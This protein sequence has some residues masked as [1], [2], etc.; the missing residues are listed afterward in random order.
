MGK[1]VKVVVIGGGIIGLNATEKL[2]SLGHDVTL[3]EKDE[4]A[5]GAS[6]GNAA[7][8]AFPEIMPLASPGIIGQAIKWMLDPL[9]PFA[10]VPQ[11]LPKTLGWLL[12]FLKASS[13][14]QFEKSIKVQGSLMGLA[15][16]SFDVMLKRR[17]LE[18]LVWTQGALHLYQKKSAFNKDLET[19]KL[20]EKKGVPFSIY[21]GEALH[22]FQPGLDRSFIA[23]FYTPTWKTVT[24]PN[25][26]CQTLHKCLTDSGVETIFSGVE[27]IEPNRVYLENGQILKADKIVLAAGPWS[28]KFTAE[29]GDKIPL[30]GERGYNTTLPKTA[31]DGLNR[32]LVFSEHGFIVGPLKDGVRVGGASEIAKLGR[33]ENFKRSR[34]MLTKASR[35]IPN[36][37][38]ENGVEWMGARPSMPDTLPVIGYSTASKDIIYAFGHGHVGLTQS[39]ATAQLVSELVEEITPSIDITALRPDRF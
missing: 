38:T 14:K 8:L 32:T 19:W 27:K 29:L 21:E 35:F 13:R 11:D 30:I 9:G 24:N 36:F 31:F 3:V 10:V 7:G 2:Q 1:S 23:A 4:I 37:K 15:Q 5:A 16:S 34:A 22:Q 33:K 17:G 12:R 39:T 25:E 28:S 20:C 18:H 26:V 6:F